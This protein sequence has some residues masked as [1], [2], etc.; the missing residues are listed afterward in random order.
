MRKIPCK[1]CA[2]GLYHDLSA[3]VCRCGADLRE[4]PGRLTDLETIPPQQRGE[5]NPDLPVYVQKC[6]A[7][8]AE[9][10]TLDPSRGVKACWN[11]HK[12]RIAAVKPALYL[13]AEEK[14]ED[15]AAP[16]EPEEPEENGES[17]WTALLEGVQTARSGLTGQTLTL[18]ALRYGALSVTLRADQEGLPLLLGRAAEY[19]S[20]LQQDPY[21][22]NEHCYL[23][24]RDGDWVVIDNHSRNGTAVNRR[25][26]DPG[27]EQVLRDGDELTLG[28]HAASMAF[29]VQ[30]Q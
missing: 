5:I 6:S 29:R 22:G 16:E 23:T 25:F 17:L 15:A 26:L 10:F 21:V 7:C 12:A 8:G 14:Q 28:H 27:G 4:T 20:F 24:F 1:L 11:C 13:D 30:I 3:Q 19:G 2:C 9:N 18:T